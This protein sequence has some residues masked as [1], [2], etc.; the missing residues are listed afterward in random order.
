MKKTLILILFALSQ[1]QVGYTQNLEFGMHVGIGNSGFHDGDKYH[2]YD[3]NNKVSY[4]I[5]GDV[6]YTFANN[7]S[8]LSGLNIVL[9][10]GKF[11]AMGNYFPG[12]NNSTEFPEINARYLSMEVPLMLGYRINCG[13]NLSITPRIGGYSGLA[14]TSLKDYVLT[15]SD[16]K[17]EKWNCFKSY[18]KDF[19]HL[20]AMKRIDFGLAAGVE[21]QFCNHYMISFNYQQ[22]LAQLSSQYGVKKQ[23]ITLSIGYRW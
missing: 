6:Y 5:G 22:G 2:V 13:K 21:M 1:H 23:N 8:L 16:N 20:E 14:L 10:G 4:E 11:S 9:F 17:K 18:D 15:S 3:C 12:F 7:L 19:H